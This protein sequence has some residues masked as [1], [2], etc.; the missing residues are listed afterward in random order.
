VGWQLSVPQFGA[1]L[2]AK[3]YKNSE[4][5]FKHFKPVRLVEPDGK[6]R[7]MKNIII[8]GFGCK[9]EKKQLN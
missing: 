1:G 4:E 6:K 7:Y 2:G 5:A 8:N 3:I 9:L